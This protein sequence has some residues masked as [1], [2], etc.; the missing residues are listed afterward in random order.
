MLLYIPKT[1]FTPTLFSQDTH[2][3]EVLEARLRHIKV[4]ST[5]GHKAQNNR[6]AHKLCFSR[7]EGGWAMFP[8]VRVNYVHSDGREPVWMQVWGPKSNLNPFL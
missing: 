6:T 2:M 4:W 8:S 3:R 7:C 1:T 5:Q